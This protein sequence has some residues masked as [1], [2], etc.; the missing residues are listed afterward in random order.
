M[1]ARRIGIFYQPTGNPSP[2]NPYR[3]GI[4]QMID[5]ASR[6]GFATTLFVPLGSH[7]GALPAR[8]CEVVAC[9]TPFAD[10]TGVQ[11]TFLHSLGQAPMARLFGPQESTVEI[12]AH[13]RA[14]A[15]LPGIQP[16]IARRFRDKHVMAERAR[17]LDIRTARG[18]RVASYEDI[19]AFASEVG[20]PIIVK[21]CD[22]AGAEGVCK[23]ESREALDREW[24]T[25][26]DQLHRLR[27]EEFITGIEYHVDTIVQGGAVAFT[28]LSRY[29]RPLL[30]FREQPPGSVIRT[31]GFT[32]GE[33]AILRINARLFPGF[34]LDTGVSHDEYFVRADTGEAVLGEV[35]ARVG[36]GH[37]VAT[38]EA[39]TGVNLFAEM[40]RVDLVAA[41]YR[42]QLTRDREMGGQLLPTHASG[43]V[44][45]ITPATA[46][47]ALGMDDVRY[48]VAKGDVV[49]RPARSTRMV[50]AVV[51]GGRG[52][53]DIAGRL[54]AA[55]GQFTVETNAGIPATGESSPGADMVWGKM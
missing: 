4:E 3:R 22:A 14:A 20:W 34:G 45:A 44:T 51:A 2:A 5:T 7:A 25:V 33:A 23:I 16:A 52:F 11:T 35:S 18:T 32:A 48:W 15:G 28:R 39:A 12:A 47:Y 26:A 36:G 30:H 40:V 17:F 46:L 41:D 37:A 55:L 24:P 53:D 6:L 49:Q 21:P 54:L 19:L 29:L 13:C 10:I 50:G 1:N 9:D 42:V 38:I 31:A 27:V 8:P 43:V